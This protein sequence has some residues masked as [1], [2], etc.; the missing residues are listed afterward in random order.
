MKEME[1][2]HEY[3]KTIDVLIHQHWKTIEEKDQETDD[4]RS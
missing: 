1:G 3:V 2:D 4:F